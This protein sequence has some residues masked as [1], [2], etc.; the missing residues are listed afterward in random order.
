M[1]SQKRWTLHNL[2]VKAQNK[3]EL[4]VGSEPTIRFAHVT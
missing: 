1:G 4:D 2:K 3:N